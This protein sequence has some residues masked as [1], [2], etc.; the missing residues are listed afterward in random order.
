MRITTASFVILAAALFACLLAGAPLVAQPLVW[1][2]SEEYPA[3]SIPGEGDSMFAALVRDKTAGRI[4]IEPKFDAALGYRS[5]QTLDAVAASAV[6]L[7]DMY[8]GALGEAEPFFL[9]P[10]LPFL[11][12]SIEQA[13]LLYDAA[14]PDYDAVLARHN[15]K[16]LFASLW[17]PSGIWARRPIADEAALR[18]L[19]V[20]TFDVTATETF[21]RLEAAPALI[22]FADAMPRLRAG[23][24]DAVLSSGD[25]GA[26][27]KL[28][29]ILPHFTE[30]NYAMPLSIATIGL[31][32]WRALPDDLQAALAAAAAETETRQW[33]A[34]RGRVAANYQRMTANGVT[35][36]AEI[37]PALAARL[38][39]AGAVAVEDWAARLGADGAGVLARYRSRKL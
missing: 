23:E 13:R 6:P 2:L 20:R 7:G 33:R 12:V 39:Q 29:E 32:A 14:R 34:M 3:T 1:N 11:A 31:D 26:G 15:Q 27:A 30:V 24:L 37:A 19:R 25:G 17:P 5:K 36:T 22:S 16:L 4:V 21:R 8:A 10:S 35:I 38:R 18:G 28:W 9:L